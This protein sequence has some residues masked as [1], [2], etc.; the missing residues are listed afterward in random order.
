M[1]TY[2]LTSTDSVFNFEA[3][4]R[5]DAETHAHKLFSDAKLREAELAEETARDQWEVFARFGRFKAAD[6]GK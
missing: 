5:T 1:N 6:E 2:R 3:A 4:S